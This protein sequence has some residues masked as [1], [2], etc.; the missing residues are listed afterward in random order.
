M[1]DIR[2]FA[3]AALLMFAHLRD[4]FDLF[5]A[6]ATRRQNVYARRCYHI[7]AFYFTRVVAMPRA[8]RYF[9]R[10]IHDLRS[11]YYF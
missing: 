4:D 5:D 6:P 3:D 1:F 11:R 9:I 2:Y 7:P 10:D 8:P